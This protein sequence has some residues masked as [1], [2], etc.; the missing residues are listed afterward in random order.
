MTKYGLL[1]RSKI[2]KP[3][4][5]RKKKMA[6]IRVGKNER[7]VA[8]TVSDGL[9][10]GFVGKAFFVWD[11]NR[12]DVP[13]ISIKGVKKTAYLDQ[14]GKKTIN[15]LKMF[16][17]EYLNLLNEGTASPMHFKECKQENKSNTNTKPQEETISGVPLWMKEDCKEWTLCRKKDGS[18]YMRRTRFKEDS[19]SIIEQYLPLCS[20]CIYRVD[21]KKPCTDPIKTSKDKITV[22]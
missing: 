7:E 2:T 22:K 6:K 18:T 15:Q 20:K 19:R 14:R 21:C 9:I 16:V 3:K 13:F 11:T 10:K 1:V 12:Y 5:E 4:E 17:E 8:C